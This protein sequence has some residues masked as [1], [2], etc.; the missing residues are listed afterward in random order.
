MRKAY[1]LAPEAVKYSKSLNIKIEHI[2]LALQNEDMLSFCL[3]I[4]PK[5]GGNVIIKP[6]LHDLRWVIEVD[7]SPVASRY[8]CVKKGNSIHIEE[9]EYE[10]ANSID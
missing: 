7:S 4:L 9:I 2:E 5:I 1:L 10:S 8:I 6:S 3:A